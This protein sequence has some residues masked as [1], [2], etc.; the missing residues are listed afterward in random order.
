MLFDEGPGVGLG[1]RR[2]IET[3]GIELLSRGHECVFVSLNET[4]VEAV[5]ADAVVIDSYRVRAD[6]AMFARRAW[7]ARVDDL[8]RRPRSGSRDRSFA[9]RDRRR[10]PTGPAGAGRRGER[11]VPE[12]ESDCRRG[13][14]RGSRGASA[15]DNRRGRHRASAHAVAARFIRACR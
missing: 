12:L 15:R 13:V 14:S 2:R 11:S 1:H 6:D 5:A 4:T 10:S 8:S 7:W 3:L 9:R